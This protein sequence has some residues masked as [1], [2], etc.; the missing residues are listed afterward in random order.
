MRETA[1][2]KPDT[3]HLLCSG[4]GQTLPRDSRLC[5]TRPG[6]TTSKLFDGLIWEDTFCMCLPLPCPTQRRTGLK[7][8]EISFFFLFPLEVIS[9]KLILLGDVSWPQP[10]NVFLEK[11]F[12]AALRKSFPIGTCQWKL[13]A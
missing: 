3:R 1:S 9:G 12:L 6:L 8:D 13:P 7:Q 5:L 11:L 10:E 2:E 4:G